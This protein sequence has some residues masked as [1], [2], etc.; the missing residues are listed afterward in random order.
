MRDGAVGSF[1]IRPSDKSPGDYSLSLRYQDGVTRFLIRRQGQQYTMGGRVFCSIDDVVKRYKHEHIVEGLSLNEPV[2]RP[3]VLEIPNRPTTPSNRCSDQMDGFTFPPQTS[4]QVSIINT[5]QQASKRGYLVKKGHRNKWKRMFCVLDADEQRLSFFEN[6]KRTKPK[7]LLDLTF[8]TVYAVLESFFGR[9]NCFQVVV[10]A[11]GE[12]RMTYLCADTPDLAN[13]WMDAVQKICGKSK[14]LDVIDVDVKQLRSLELNVIEAH[15]LPLNKVSHPYCMVSLNEVKTCRTKT[16]EGQTP[17]WNEEFKFNDLPSDVS[18]FT[19]SL[20]N[21]S[22]RTKDVLIGH[23][24][25]P[26][27]KLPKGQT[28]DDWYPLAAASHGKAE[29]GN[30]RIRVKFT[31]EIIMPVEEYEALKEILLDEDLVAVTALGQVCKDRVVLAST[32]LKIFRHEKQEIFLLKTMNAR[33]IEKQDEQATLF[34]GASLA[35]S[36]MDQYMKMVAIPYLQHTIKDVILKILECKQSCELNPAKMEKGADTVVNLKQLLE[37]LF[38]AIDAIFTSAEECPKTLR[39]LF[40]CLQQNVKDKWADNQTV[41]TRVVS[42]FLFLRL[43]CP[44]IMNPKTCN[45]MSELPS[46]TAARTLTLVAKCL[47]KLANLVEFGAKE[48]CMTPV[49]PFMQKNRERMVSFMDELSDVRECPKTHE[50]V[51]SD[52]ARDLASLHDLCIVYENE[53]KQLST[54]QTDLKKLVSVIE[55]LRRREQQY[56]QESR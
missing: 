40:G 32:L 15:K 39:Y 34:R 26:L 54:T 46:A 41:R 33:E 30:V 14:S 5:S 43:F 56:V 23:V 13:E 24:L 22:W 7:M 9:P 18:S 37:F 12:S 17:L 28:V 31:H 35:T 27:N 3:S 1:M 53:L 16:F 19:L 38:E 11:L 48:S 6:E 10:R 21:K 2:L 52:P 36:L 4:G 47:Q 29:V 8:S 49:N 45:L 44:A 51:S 42:G 25:V 55:A 50:Q 20:Y